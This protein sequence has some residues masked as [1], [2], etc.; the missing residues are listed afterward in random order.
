MSSD[1]ESRSKRQCRADSRIIEEREIRDGLAS[2]PP[3]FRLSRMKQHKN[4]AK[5]WESF[6]LVMQIAFEEDE[7]KDSRSGYAR[8]DVCH[9]LYKYEAATGNHHLNRHAATHAGSSTNVSFDDTINPSSSAKAKIFSAATEYIGSELLPFRHIESPGLKKMLNEVVAV[10]VAEGKIDVDKLLPGRT[11]VK[12]GIVQ[13]YYE[14]RPF[15]L[16]KLK[17]MCD[18]Q[19]IGIIVDH[20]KNKTS[21]VTIMGIAASYVVDN[22]VHFK[23]IDMKPFPHAQK[24]KLNNLQV[25]RSCLEEANINLD[26]ADVVFTT[27]EGKY[28]PGL[29]TSFY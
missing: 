4:H 8:C 24:T 22:D 18:V 6:Q 7:K 9:L 15:L 17:K 2:T 16:A 23:L 19:G 1:N 13:H 5:C 21:G 10:V 29:R 26:Q 25:L 28:C 14:T 12:N 20:W 11:A 27:D 3:R